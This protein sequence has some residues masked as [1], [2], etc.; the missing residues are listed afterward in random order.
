MPA[1]HLIK[2]SEMNL[3]SSE[4][5]KL[6]TKSVIV[7]EED[8]GKATKFA[9]NMLKFL[10]KYPYGC[11]LSAV[12]VGRMQRIFVIRFQGQKIICINPDILRKSNSKNW[13]EEGCLSFPGQ[14]R[15]IARPVNITAKYFDGKE[16][17]TKEFPGMLAR[18]Y[19]HEF[20]HLNGIV[21]MKK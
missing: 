10:N 14:T 8:F 7:E 16:Y 12:Q 17:V 3:I 20:D 1:T 21:C 15:N 4:N 5:K 19:Q 18:I 6:Y 11:G 2:E 13:M 9:K